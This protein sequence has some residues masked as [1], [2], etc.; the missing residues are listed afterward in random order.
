MRK[1]LVIALVLAA[2]FYAKGLT[3]LAR[4]T[5]DDKPDASSV[6]SPQA[7]ED[8]KCNLC[9]GSGQP[10]SATAQPPTHDGGGVPP[11]RST[12]CCNGDCSAVVTLPAP[13]PTGAAPAVLNAFSHGPAHARPEQ[14]PVVD[15]VNNIWERGPPRPASALLG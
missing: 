14:R 7:A 8:A 1:A 5:C 4:C 10:Y 11:T 15:Q 9:C 6:V 3:W 13:V 12:D 2:P